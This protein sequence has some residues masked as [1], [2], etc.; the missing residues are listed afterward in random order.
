MGWTVWNL[1]PIFKRQPKLIPEVTVE[2]EGHVVTYVTETFSGSSVND[3]IQKAK[4]K[5]HGLR[6]EAIDNKYVAGVCESCGTPLFDGDDYAYDDEGIIWC[7]E[8]DSPDP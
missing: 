8:C 6:I 3:C 1:L 7:R 4:R 5:W 2:I